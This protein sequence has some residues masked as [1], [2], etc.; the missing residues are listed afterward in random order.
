MESVPAGRP[1]APG[2]R[3]PRPPNSLPACA[4][5]SRCWRPTRRRLPSDPGWA[6]EIKWDG[7]R[8]FAVVAD[9]AARLV[10]RRGEDLTSRYPELAP[11]GA[12]LDGR[13]AT[14]DGEIVAIGEDGRP[15][16]QRLQRRMGVTAP[17]TIARRVPETPVTFIAFDLLELDGDD[18]RK[19]PY[20]ERRELLHGPRAHLRALADAPPPPRGRAGAARGGAA[21]G[22]RGSR[23]QAARQRLPAGL[24]QPRLDQGPAQA[25][26]GLPDRRLAWRR[27]RSRQPARGAAAGRLGR[28]PG[29]GRGAGLPAALAVQRRRRQRSRGAD[30]RPARPSCSRRS[31]GRRARSS[32]RS[33]APSARTLTSSS[34][35]SSARSSSASGPARTRCA[36]RRSRACGTTST[37]RRSCARANPRAASA[38][39][40]S[41]ALTVGTFGPVFR[42]NV[43]IVGAR[44]A[45]AAPRRP[46]SSGP[47]PG[48]LGMNTQDHMPPARAAQERVLSSG[49]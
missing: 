45:A 46:I 29:G 17:L 1:P 36:S 35:A 9:G 18:L 11:L 30:D 47:G 32:P 41:P 34:P 20:E 13:S 39:R 49:N 5:S 14:L 12:A 3:T 23:C 33:A 21:A 26:P 37:R 28:R 6:F 38:R 24:P 10:S 43:P 40:H 16:F 7:V 4:R 19:R 22:A 2:A 42:G 8:A 44:Q 25:A 31:R 15:S 27:R 48:L